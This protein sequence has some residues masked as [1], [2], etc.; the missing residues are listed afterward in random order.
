MTTG[1][2]RGKKRR[3]RVRGRMKSQQVI[4]FVDLIWV[5]LH[6][7]HTTRLLTKDEEVSA[8]EMKHI[9]TN[10]QQPHAQVR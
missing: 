6:L 7:Y 4:G 1:K 10:M 3:K 8:G 9:S 5:H 2:D